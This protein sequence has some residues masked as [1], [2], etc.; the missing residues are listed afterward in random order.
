M[1]SCIQ[2]GFCS[3]SAIY[4]LEAIALINSSLFNTVGFSMVVIS[5][6]SF[7]ISAGFNCIQIVA[8]S[9]LS[10]NAISSLISIHLTTFT[11]VLRSMQRLLPQSWWMSLHLSDVCNNGAVRFRVPPRTHNILPEIPARKSSLQEN[12][13]A[14]DTISLIT[15][16]S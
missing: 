7:V 3:C 4:N 2:Y 1:F 11:V 12:Q 15:S 9:S 13:N 8:F 14:E 5:A 16:P 10:A 6:R